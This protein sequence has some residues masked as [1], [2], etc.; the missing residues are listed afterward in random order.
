M[1]IVANLVGL[2][3]VRETVDR[4]TKEWFKDGKSKEY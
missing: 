4:L 2:S 3:K 1:P